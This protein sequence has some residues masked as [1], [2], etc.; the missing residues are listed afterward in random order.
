MPRYG[1]FSL[2]K[3]RSLGFASADPDYLALFGLALAPAHAP[4]ALN[5]AGIG[6]S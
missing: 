1:H 4:E 6:N 3:G 5:L 2:A